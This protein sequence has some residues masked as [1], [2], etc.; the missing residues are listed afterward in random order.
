MSRNDLYRFTLSEFLNA[1]KGYTDE[2][3]LDQRVQFE[4]AQ[5]VLSGLVKKVPKMPWQIE[6]TKPY[7]EEEKQAIAAAH[8][9]TTTNKQIL[10]NEGWKDV[11]S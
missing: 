3:Q 2:K 8:N 4:A 10:T 1:W 7:T 5:M 6:E 11:S 9:K